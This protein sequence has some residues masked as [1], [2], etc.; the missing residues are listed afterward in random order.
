MM[1]EELLGKGRGLSHID[2][3]N[4]GD[5]TDQNSLQTIANGW[6]PSQTLAQR[7]AA[8]QAFE[9]ALHASHPSCLA[10]L[11]LQ[12]A[13]ERDTFV[14]L[15]V[16][17]ARV[18]GWEEVTPADIVVSPLRSGIVK[19]SARNA[20]SNADCVFKT[21]G[22][23]RIRAV[24]QVLSDAGVATTLL[25]S[26]PGWTAEQFLTGRDMGDGYW[27]T[28]RVEFS[29][30]A[31]LTA[32][33]HAAP[34]DWW[35]P[36]RDNLS[37]A[38]PLL[39]DEPD[40]SPLWS[41]AAFA[42]GKGCLS[43][44]PEENRAELAEL[45]TILP[46]PVGDLA[47]KVVNVHGDFWDANIVETD[48]NALKLVDFESTSVCGAIQDLV[49]VSNTALIEAY[50]RE[51]TG[52]QPTEDE[53]EALVFE[54]RLAEHIHFFI[55]RGIF[56][57]NE[58]NGRDPSVPA[59]NFFEHAR[60]LAV[61]VEAVRANKALRRHIVR[62]CVAEGELANPEGGQRS[63]DM[64]VK[65]SGGEPVKLLLK[66]HPGQGVVRQER[67]DV[68][69]GWGH[70]LSLGPASDAARV[71][72]ESHTSAT[73]TCEWGPVMDADNYELGLHIA[74]GEQYAKRPGNAVLFGSWDQPGFTLNADSTMSPASN[75]SLVLGHGPCTCHGETMN[76]R[77]AVL[78]VDKGSKEQLV[79]D[80]VPSAEPW[81]SIR[82]ENTLAADVEVGARMW[83]WWSA[84]QL[85][86]ESDK[87]ARL[88]K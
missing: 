38:L 3:T 25:A 4:R 28:G 48:D 64:G 79:F 1:A 57:L 65:P 59:S 47:N 15:T 35:T 24:H 27:E 71:V 63:F 51:T 10:K 76:G 29:R 42:E 33:L 81:D 62:G 75:P 56:R 53:F 82:R 55:L 66:S 87:V 36:F 23:A 61:V 49:H 60:R 30:F 73:D 46:R 19:L 2:T 9:E 80:L 50:L 54:A 84:E 83:C 77:D 21:R 72:I 88:L 45:M 18:P 8:A 31:E 17:G 78:F 86:A 16:L 5:L 26:G 6:G 40:S 13:K 85:A 32:R 43:G 11:V 20:T 74:E 14:A 22:T 41:M 70:F 68:A 44:L 52:Q 37:Q 69:G 12:L 34:T 7:E 58:E 67:I 39:N